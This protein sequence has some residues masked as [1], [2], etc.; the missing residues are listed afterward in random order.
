MASATRDQ[1][2]T[3]LAIVPAII[4]ARMLYNHKQ[5]VTNNVIRNHSH[6]LTNDKEGNS[7]DSG[8]YPE[9]NYTHLI[10]VVISES[11]NGHLLLL[12]CEKEAN[13]KMKIPVVS[14]LY[15]LD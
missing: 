7:V 4:F 13:K 12:W 3:F 5:Q 11:W 1:V 8:L 14:E 15:V 2:I 10:S 6:L 9:R